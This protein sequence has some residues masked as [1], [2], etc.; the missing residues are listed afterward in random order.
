MARRIVGS[1]VGLL[2]IAY[3]V[4]LVVFRVEKFQRLTLTEGL[5]RV[6]NTPSGPI[7][8]AWNGAGPVVLVIP[9]TFG[10]FDQ[11]L[12][13]GVYLTRMGFKVLG[14][15]RP[16][17]LGTPIAT[18]RTPAEQGDAYAALLDSL[19]LGTVA[20]V[21]ASGGGPSTLELA[22]RHPS[23]VDHLVL[24]AALSGSKA[25]PPTRPSRLTAVTDRLWGDGFLMWW[26]LRRYEASG[27]KVLDSP[28]FSPD[29][30]R[31][32]AEDS[33][34]LERF[35]RLAWFR[36]PPSRRNDGYLNDREQFGKFAFSRFDAITASTLVVHGTA[37]RNV[38]IEHGER[39][40]ASVS[41]AEYLKIE[42]GDHY[43]SI[44][45]RDEVWSRV[46]G[47]L[48]KPGVAGR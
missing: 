13:L 34:K 1:A 11:A 31:R 2:L 17:Y 30:Q 23:R 22:S 8:Y 43:V 20:V 19:R 44:A 14:V 27:R 10:G 47:F 42:G 40:A 35:F 12:E 29:S 5:S 48:R 33:T 7:E 46:A 18:G 16:G 28:I 25:Q 21:A 9:G 32:L 38:P 6:V 3:L 41:G 39:T 45:H 37:D 15:S 24:I 26:E 4:L 36:F